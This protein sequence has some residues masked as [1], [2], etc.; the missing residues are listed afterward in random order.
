MVREIFTINVG[1][2][3]IELGS[4]IWA[5]YNLEHN[6]DAEGNR[7]TNNDTDNTFQCFY[8]ET[9]GGKYVPICI[10][11]D[12]E[13]DAIDNLK[14]SKYGKLFA[15]EFLLSAKDGAGGCFA[16]GHYT[17]GKEIV[18]KVIDRS[19]KVFDNFDNQQGFIINHS[20]GGGTGSGLASL[21]L[22]RIT[23]DYRR[24]SKF[25]FE[26]YPFNN[27]YSNNYVETYNALLATHRLLDLTDLSFIFDNRQL[28]NICRDKLLFGRPS[29]FDINSII[30]KIVSGIT[31]PVRFEND[32]II[33]FD[34]IQNNTMCFPRL[35]FL[36]SSMAPL[37]LTEQCRLSAIERKR[38]LIDG[39]VRDNSM[40]LPPLYQDIMNMIYSVYDINVY[41]RSSVKELSEDLINSEYFSVECVD[42]D[43]KEDKY[44]HIFVDYRGDVDKMSAYTAFD[45]MRKKTKFSEWT[46]GGFKFGLQEIM[47]KLLENDSVNL[48]IGKRQG[49][50]IGN[51]TFI[52]RFF[53]ERIS[54]VYDKMYSQRAYV[55]W[56]LQEG[57]EEGEFAEARED[58]G[59]MEEDY[60]DLLSEETTTE[61]SES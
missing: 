49:V 16:R 6:I 8:R 57:M 12:L 24:K 56:F 13:P 26:I 2:A 33:N 22:E 20:V 30:A 27:N 19:R 55:H 48:R 50:F 17:V 51:N 54:K 59:F 31:A 41:D 35:H 4:T 45:G 53:S 28:F 10:M 43:A 52:S 47:P 40:A 23:V 58:L 9:Y 61:V 39:Y 36:V 5:Q 60:L 1:G 21:I 42:F 15:S 18:D 38:M 32:D 14:A 3:G 11:V 44:T 25:G 34:D 29:Y 7:S 37:L 46:P